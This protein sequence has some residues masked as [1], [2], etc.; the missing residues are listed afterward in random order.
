MDVPT[1][2]SLPG[3]AMLSR[4]MRDIRRER[5]LR[6]VDVAERMGMPLRSYE[7]FE[8]GRGKLSLERLFAFAEATRSDPFALVAAMLLGS[9]EFAQR[10][11]DNKLM[12]VAILSLK[13]LNE[14]L[15][16]DLVYLET[17][18]LIGG[19]TRLVKELVQDVRGRDTFAEQWLADRKPGKW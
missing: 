11:A 3:H 17:G 9:P 4:A 13:E 8:S 10:C 18:K 15:G 6:A 19:F 16:D 5:R 14:E 2:Q 1:S 12:Q 7:H